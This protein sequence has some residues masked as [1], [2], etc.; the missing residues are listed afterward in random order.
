M[1]RRVPSRTP[2]S[3]SVFGIWPTKSLT[4][5]VRCPSRRPLTIGPPALGTGGGGGCCEG[6]VGWAGGGGGG[7]WAEGEA[8]CDRVPCGGCATCCVGEPC[9]GGGG[10]GA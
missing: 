7:G 9:C 3:S 8:G 10:G 6:D 2:S 4:T 1:T 5:S